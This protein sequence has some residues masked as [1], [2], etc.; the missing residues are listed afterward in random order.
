[1]QIQIRY[2]AIFGVFLLLLVLSACYAPIWY[3][4]AG[5]FIV[6]REF[7]SEGVACYPVDLGAGICDAQSPFITLG[8]A[9]NY[10]LAG[11]MWAF[12]PNMLT[13]RIF[14]VMLA[15]G[16]M[17]AFWM[18]ARRLLQPQK[19]F[20]ALAL[21]LGNVQLVTYGSEILGE[22]PM[23]GWLFLGLALQLDWWQN[24][25]W[26][27]HLAATGAYVLAILSKEYVALPLAMGL[28]AWMVYWLWMRQ[29][30][31]VLAI[32]G[33]GLLIG[34]AIIGYHLA[35]T[36]SWEAF[37]A[38]FQ[39]RG[40]YGAEFFS[41]NLGESLRFLLFKP[42]ILLGSIALLIKVWMR[43]AAPDI[44][45]ACFHFAHLFFFLSSAGYDRFGFQLIFIPAIYLAEFM[46]V[47]W[48]RFI[49]KQ[50]HPRLRQM[51]FI[52]SFLLLFTQQTFPILAQRILSSTSSNLAEETVSALISQYHIEQI[53]TYDQQL[54][55]FLPP[56]VRFRLSPTVPSNSSNCQ[57]LSLH[58]AEWLIAGIYAQT[59]FQ[60]C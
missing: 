19:A 10:P 18:L 56:K 20:W 48:K 21:V 38:W 51:V 2:V 22:V 47:I 8:P 45:I 33:Q 7:V 39:A 40:S 23:L 43:R 59:S 6:I 5:H 4:D 58:S 17:L 11:W 28:G 26:R 37:F 9:L 46:A 36:G 30:R 27:A 60:N 14:M 12:G 57:P 41:F 16:A 52:F 35:K 1:M 42:L 31:Q 13:G 34:L 32:L 49:L 55:P 50:P 29:A 24:G 3:D 15:L 53:Y 54:I 25:S 44:L